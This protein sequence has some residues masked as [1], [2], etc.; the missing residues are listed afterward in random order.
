LH[1]KGIE[2][3]DICD[4]VLYFDPLEQ[5]LP[6]IEYD[7]YGQNIKT[8]FRKSSLFDTIYY[9]S[10]YQLSNDSTME[11]FTVGNSDSAPLKSY[12]DVTLSPK[13]SYKKANTSVYSEYN[14]NY[15]FIGGTWNEDQLIFSTRDFG[16]YT[17]LMDS[18]PPII[19]PNNVGSKS[20][21]FK[22]EDALSG[23]KNFNV[24][25]NGKWILAD[26]DYKTKLI[27]SFEDGIQLKKDDELKV[28]VTDNASNE[29]IYVT[30]IK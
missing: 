16:N 19:T 20:F 11:F 9:A 28:I 3:I 10:S 23:I 21:K 26:Y 12:L 1:K 25:V 18:V 17:I 8:H 29:A 6:N 30:K 5:V 22:I 7:F 27:W 15:Y 24:F 14:G 2:S 4:S 13:K